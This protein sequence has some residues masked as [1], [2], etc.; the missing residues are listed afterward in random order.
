MIDEPS[1]DEQILACLRDI[2][3][4]LEGIK[5]DTSGILEAL[6]SRENTGTEPV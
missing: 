3:L 1:I 2:L 6:T 4:E 5:D